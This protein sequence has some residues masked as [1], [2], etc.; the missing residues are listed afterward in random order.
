MKTFRRK[1][2]FI[3]ILGAI[4]LVLYLIWSY[5][6]AFKLIEDEAPFD[7]IRSI[8]LKPFYRF[9][10]PSSH[11]TMKCNRSIPIYL[12]HGRPSDDQFQ[13]VIQSWRDSVHEISIIDTYNMSHSYRNTQC[14]YFQ[15]HQRL[16]HIYQQ[17][18]HHVLTKDHPTDVGFVFIEDDVLLLNPGL[19]L[20][21]LCIAQ[22]YEFYSFYETESNRER[23]SSSCLYNYG[24]P[25]FYIK[26]SLMKK[27]IHGVSS[28]EFCRLPIDMYLATLG[29]WYKV[30]T[31]EMIVQHIGSRLQVGEHDTSKRGSVL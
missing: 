22:Q 17:V 11:I 25:A 21:Q 26:Q 4:T 6:Q 15:W 18:F 29:P 5:N 14:I 7:H 1:R 28:D 19:F 8:L 31:R 16:F 12:V 13:R 23:W 30:S 3:V 27:V 10:C 2:F 9:S 24:T 20:D